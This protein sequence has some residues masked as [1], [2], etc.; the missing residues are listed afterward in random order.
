[1]TKL[2]RRLI[3]RTPCGGAPLGYQKSPRQ[4]QG[5]SSQDRPARRNFHGGNTPRVEHEQSLSVSASKHAGV[6]RQR[7]DNVLNDLGFAARI[8][9]LVRDIQALTADEA[10]S[11]HNAFHV[12][13]P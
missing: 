1:M 12:S 11:Q 9:L 4:R 6:I 5:G 13:A 8:R 10:D 3:D 7:G 2:G